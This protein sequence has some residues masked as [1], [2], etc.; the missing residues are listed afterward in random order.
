MAKHVN[1]YKE[2]DRYM[3]YALIA[4]SIFYVTYLVAACVGLIWLKV[5]MAI[6]A[7]LVS[8][9]CLVYLF[10]SQ[11][12]LKPRSLWMTTGAAAVILCT[13]VSLVL[14]FPR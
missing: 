11:E 13:L 10:L 1:R 5:V 8:G 7:F 12:L 6:I 14:N 2:L 3:T 9:L 4:D